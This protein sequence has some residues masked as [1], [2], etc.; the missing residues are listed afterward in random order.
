M[1]R[2]LQ[3][4]IDTDGID[5]FMQVEE[6]VV[7]SLEVENTVIATGGSVVYSE[8]AMEDL[9]RNG[10]C[11]Y[12]YVDFDELSKRLSNITTRGIV[13]KNANTLREVWQERLPL[14]QKYATITVDCSKNTIEQS[15]EQIIEAL[16]RL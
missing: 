12:L 2:R 9:S 7:T 10:I 1:G 6:Q 3:N 15:V 4:I 5:A 14:Y 16:D 11:V 8:A 13:F